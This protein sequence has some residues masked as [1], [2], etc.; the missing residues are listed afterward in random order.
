MAGVAAGVAADVAVGVAAAGHVTATHPDQEVW[1]DGQFG[2]GAAGERH[3]RH[4]S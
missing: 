3:G 2:H 1:Q 4:G